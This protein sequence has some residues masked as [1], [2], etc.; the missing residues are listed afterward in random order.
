MDLKTIF[1]PYCKINMEI[2]SNE[3]KAIATPTAFFLLLTEQY[4]QIKL[5]KLKFIKIKNFCVS[6]DYIKNVKRQTVKWEKIFTNHISDKEFVSRHVSP[7]IST[8]KRKQKS[9]NNQ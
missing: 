1:K 5:H 8:T 3:K 6:K 4:I 2:T 9:K 7:Y